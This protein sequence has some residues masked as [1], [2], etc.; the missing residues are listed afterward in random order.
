M[1]VITKT[2]LGLVACA[3]ADVTAARKAS[4]PSAPAMRFEPLCAIAS[5]LSLRRNSQLAQL[6]L[7]ALAVQP[8]G[9]GGAGDVAAVFAQLGFDIGDFELSFGFAVVARREKGRQPV[10]PG[11]GSGRDARAPKEIAGKVFGRE[12]V[13]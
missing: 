9:S 11:A 1:S 2:F 3:D 5:S 7:Q 6:L 13:V 12:H 8:D 10:L 4:A